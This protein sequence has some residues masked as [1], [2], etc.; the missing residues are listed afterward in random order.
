MRRAVLTALLLSA[1]CG[2]RQQV[3]LHGSPRPPLGP[4]AVGRP[5]PG[6]TVRAYDLNHDG[7]PDVWVYAVAGAGGSE[8]VVR[9]EKDLDGDGHIDTWEQVRAD[10]TPSRLSYDMDFDGTPDL[11]LSFEG[12]QLVLKEYAFGGDGLP[13]TINVYEQGRLVRRERDA[14]GDGQLVGEVTGTSAPVPAGAPPSGKASGGEPQPQDHLGP[15]G[16]ARVPAPAD[17]QR[18]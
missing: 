17:R 15:G 1:A 8:V 13:R 3:P 9:R 14:G 10:G 18:E 6:E 2:A 11:T 4:R 12:D 16:G 7:R 5:G